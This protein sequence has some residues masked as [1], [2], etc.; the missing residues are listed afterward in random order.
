MLDSTT[1]NSNFNPEN[2]HIARYEGVIVDAICSQ[3][4]LFGDIDM[5]RFRRKEKL[6]KPCDYCGGDAFYRFAS[7]KRSYCCKNHQNKCP[8]M[9]R[10]LSKN[11]AMR[12]PEVAAKVS[13]KNH[14]NWKGK[15]T[16]FCL[17]CGKSKEIYASEKRKRSF[18]NNQCH[19]KWKKENWQGKD[20]HNYVERIIAFCSHC[21]KEKEIIPSCK[22]KYNFCNRKCFGKWISENLI[23]ENGINWQG[24]KSF[25][26]YCAV[27]TD[28][29]Y[30]EYVLNRDNNKCQ[31]PDCWENCNHLS[32]NRHHINYNKEDCHYK[33][34]ITVCRSC[35]SR[36]N[37]NR[38][39]WTKLYQEIMAKKYGYQYD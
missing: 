6:L 4:F 15:I 34:I 16:V 35:N 12:R 23:G 38:E 27:W 26:Q 2:L 10:V 19:G 14:G 8:G 30:Q 7:G 11:N 1:T 13:K 28:K 37:G 9:Q 18:C 21:G 32:M 17:Q 20:N 22:A 33:N 36:A 25:E 3:G 24:G 39:Y 5:S 29:E 31:N